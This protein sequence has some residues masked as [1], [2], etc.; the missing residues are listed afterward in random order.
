MRGGIKFNSTYRTLL[1]E[2]MVRVI[3]KP[4]VYKYMPTVELEEFISL[5]DC[6]LKKNF[7]MNSNFSFLFKKNRS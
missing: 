2:P 4:Y 3:L 7:Q 5:I 1:V 6:I